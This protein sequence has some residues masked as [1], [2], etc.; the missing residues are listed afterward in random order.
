MHGARPVVAGAVLCPMGADIAGLLG[1][2]GAAGRLA[3]GGVPGAVLAE[4]RRHVV[5][6]AAIEPEAVFGEHLADRVLLLERGRHRRSPGK[7]GSID[8][9]RLLRRYAPRNDDQF[10][11]IASE[12]KQSRG[13]GCWGDRA[14]LNRQP[15][16]RAMPAAGPDRPLPRAISR[17]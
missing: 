11:V 2:R 3:K 15:G 14:S 10:V 9:V 17:A 16:W 4:Q 13:R 6:A 1:D 12:A 5:I 7:C 8:P